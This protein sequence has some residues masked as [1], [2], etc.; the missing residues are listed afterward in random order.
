[1]VQYRILS[2]DEFPTA[3][4]L[5]VDVFGVEAPYFQTLLEGGTSDDFSLGAFEGDRLVSS[6][7]VFMRRYRDLAGVPLKV[8]GIGSVSTLPE[9][10]SKGYSSQLLQMSILEMAERKCIWS[11]LGT[12]VNDHY[13]RHGWRTVST[14]GFIGTLWPSAVSSTIQ[15]S[16]VTAPLLTAMAAVH[17]SHSKYLP[18]ANDRSTAMW[19]HAI[20]YRVSEP[21]DEV[22]ISHKDSELT[23]YLVCRLKDGQL[24]LVE[25]ACREGADQALRDLVRQRLRM[26]AGQGLKRAICLLPK[27]NEAF[28]SFIEACQRIQPAEDRA[29]MVRPIADRIPWP[30]LV[31][32]HADPRGRRSDLDNF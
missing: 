17:A 15:P 8:G 6:V 23:A 3:V 7:H 22:Y 4:K 20:R 9:A 26:A 1:M 27:G 30:D 12:G 5:W 13:A 28:P 24:D 11:Y 10:R 21:T 16:K 32:L 2:A 14:P 19:N 29:W 18:M 31:A 25:A